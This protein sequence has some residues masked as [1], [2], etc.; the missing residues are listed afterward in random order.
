MAKMRSEKVI[1]G[2]KKMDVWEN[3]SE[4]AHGAFKELKPFRLVR[5]QSQW[6]EDA[7]DEVREASWIMPVFLSYVGAVVIATEIFFSKEKSGMID[8]HIRKLTSG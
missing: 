2:K 8:L 4:R 7:W 5:V 3:D 6:D 1:H